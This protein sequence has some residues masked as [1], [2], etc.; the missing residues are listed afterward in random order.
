MV[1]VEKIDQEFIELLKN[2]AKSE[3]MDDLTSI[4]IA[5]LFLEPNEVAMDDLA[6]ET[7]YSLASISNKAKLFE[8]AGLFKKTTKPGTRKIFLYME[9]D[10]SRMTLGLFL[11]KLEVL[12]VVKAKLPDIMKRYKSQA[13]TEKEKQKFK[14]MEHYYSDVLKFD[15]LLQE[16]LQKLTKLEENDN[17]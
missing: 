14:I 11:K 10:V 16:L 5:K 1:K 13:K 4:I 7:G 8:Q 9:K 12:S 6:K 2:L 17:T 15:K 3:G